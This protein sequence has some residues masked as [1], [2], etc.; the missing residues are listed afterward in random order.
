[1]VFDQVAGA[2]RPADFLVAHG[3]EDH[4]A[5]EQKLLPRQRQKGIE[6]KD[7]CAFHVDS[8]PAPD[9]AV[10]QFAAKGIDRPAA[11]VG[12]HHIH[13]MDQHNRL[14]LAR[15]F[16]P[17]SQIDFAR[18]PFVSGDWDAFPLENLLQKVSGLG[19]IPRRVGRVDLKIT[20]QRANRFADGALP[21]HFLPHGHR[22]RNH[23]K[24]PAECSEGKMVQHGSPLGM[25][26]HCLSP[27][28]CSSRSITMTD[29]RIA[30][31]LSYDKTLDK[32]G[33]ILR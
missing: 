21:V 18:I 30:R 3:Q 7:P 22:R 13:M 10:F 28:G 17:G 9:I 12:R 4:I 31:V 24:K 33:K 23:Q 1:M 16:E 19:D 32:V 8:P 2:H 11:R 25:G 29:E 20:L 6:L 14:G 27:G 5:V 26:V 15:A